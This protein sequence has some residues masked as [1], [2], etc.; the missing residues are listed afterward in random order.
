MCGDMV[1]RSNIHTSFKGAALTVSA[2]CNSG[3]TTQVEPILYWWLPLIPFLQ[4]TSSP[5]LGVGKW[6]VPV[7]NVL[8]AVYT[9]TTG[10][11]IDQVRNCWLLCLMRGGGVFI[12]GNFCIK[13]IFCN[14]SHRNTN[15]LFW[16]NIWI[17]CLNKNNPRLSRSSDTSTVPALV[18]P[19]CI[20]WAVTSSTRWCIATG[21]EC[22]YACD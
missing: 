3:H 21:C 12:I 10:L 18:P 16:R 7:I 15:F 2:T 17:L 1:D 13:N 5:F 11:H 4:W 14:P 20:I 6:A 19:W 9:F 8:L 22:R